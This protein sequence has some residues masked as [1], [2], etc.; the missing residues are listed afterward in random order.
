MKGNSEET[1]V[2]LG[3]GM[4]AVNGKNLESSNVFFNNSSDVK[5]KP[6]LKSST[7]QEFETLEDSY[8]PQ[9]T[10]AQNLTLPQTQPKNLK[11]IYSSPGFESQETARIRKS[12]NTN[13]TS[14]FGQLNLE[15]KNLSS[16]E[17]PLGSQEQ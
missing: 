11:Q 5:R 12:K 9:F 1:E 14:S 13:N 16:R 6:I 2:G 7:H 8:A 10:Q 15:S 3:Q 17:Q 4:V